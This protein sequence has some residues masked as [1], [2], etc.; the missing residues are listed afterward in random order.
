MASVA[1]CS[2]STTSASS[3]PP[4]ATAGGRGGSSCSG[5]SSSSGHGAGLIDGKFKIKR[6]IDYG[7]FSDIYIGKNVTDGEVRAKV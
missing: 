5:S 2:A 7:S 1:S 3:T 4:G 6:K